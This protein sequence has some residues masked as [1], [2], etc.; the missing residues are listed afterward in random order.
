LDRKRILVI[1]G[2][3]GIGRGIAGRFAADGANVV[4]ADVAVEEAANFTEELG[5]SAMAV[6]CDVNVA[7]EVERAVSAASERLDGLDGLVYS[8]GNDYFG[9]II[10]HPE[11]EYDRLMAVNLRGGFLAMKYAA[12]VIAAAGGGSIVNLSSIA[13]FGGLPSHAAYCAAKA[14]MIAL[15]QSAAIELRP[16]GIRVNVICPGAV[17]TPM[18]HAAREHFG[19][20][21]GRTLEEFVSASQGRLGTVEDIANLAAFLVSDASSFI[22]G[23]CLAADGGAT[24]RAF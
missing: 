7:A 2:A 6:P 20:S 14:G 23:A 22:T 17:D 8:A 5:P 15:S 9:P 24:A 11:D 18:L 12:P 16:L 10:G 4:V 13:G 3:S 21:Q 19:N 1:G